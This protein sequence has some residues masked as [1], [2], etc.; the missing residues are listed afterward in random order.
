[1]LPGFDKALRSLEVFV[2]VCCHNSTPHRNSVQFRVELVV[3]SLLQSASGGLVHGLPLDSDNRQH[4][5][6]TPHACYYLP[7]SFAL[8][9]LAE[10]PS[11]T[12]RD[13]THFLHQVV[14]GLLRHAECQY[15]YPSASCMLSP[16]LDWR[17]SATLSFSS[18]SHFL[19]P[20]FLRLSMAPWVNGLS[21]N[22]SPLCH[23]RSAILMAAEMSFLSRAPRW[24]CRSELHC[25]IWAAACLPWSTS[26]LGSVCEERTWFQC[27][28]GCE[29]S[30]SVLRFWAA[31]MH[32]ELPGNNQVCGHLMQR[33]CDQG[34][35]CPSYSE[36]LQDR[37]AN[38]LGRRTCLCAWGPAAL[39]VNEPAVSV[40]LAFSG[41]PHSFQSAQAEHMGRPL[42]TVTPYTCCNR[43]QLVL[44]ETA[45]VA[46][47]CGFLTYTPLPWIWTCGSLEWD[48][49]SGARHNF[50]SW[51]HC[52]FRAFRFG[53]ALHPG[54][55]GC[56]D[57]APQT[58]KVMV[59]NPTAIYRKEAIFHEL[60]ADL[61]GIAETSAVE[62][63]QL[64]FS[65]GMRHYGYRTV[66]GA[67]VAMHGRDV[68]ASHSMR[69]LSGGVALA[70]KLPCRSSPTAF[71]PPMA[72]TTRL[73]ES[74]VRFGVL[75]IRCLCVYGVPQ[76]HQEAKEL[77]NALLAAAWD[78]VSQN[79]VP[80]LVLGDMNIDVHSLP[81]W[82]QY[83]QLGYVEAFRA[84]KAKFDEELPPTCKSSTRFDTAIM[85]PVLVELLSA[86]T[87]LSDAH[88]FDAHSPLQLEFAV[89]PCLPT[90]HRWRL[91]RPWTDFR[92]APEALAKQYNRHADAVQD[93]VSMV[94]TR[95]ELTGAFQT[96]AGAVEAAVDVTI[97]QDGSRGLPRAFRG[98]CQPT[99]RVSYTVQQLPRRARHGDFQ[100]QIEVISVKCRQRLRQCRR[101]RT[102]LQGLRKFQQSPVWNPAQLQQ[103]FNEWHAIL[104]APGYHGRFC[105]WVLSWDFMVHFPRDFPSVAYVADLVR[106]L[107]H[108]CEALAA[109]EAALRRAAYK[110]MVVEDEVVDF[111]R[112]GYKSLQGP[113]KPPFAAV[114]T[115]VQNVAHPEA[116]ASKGEWQFRMREAHLYRP[117]LQV[118]FQG[119]PGL[120]V[121]VNDS[122]VHAS[123]GQDLPCTSG[124]LTQHHHDCTPAEL[125]TGFQKFWQTYWLRDSP[126]EEADV[127]QWRQFLDLL[128][129]FPCPWESFELDLRDVELWVQ[130]CKKMKSRSATGACGFSVR[131]LKM[132]PRVALQQL[133]H[134]FHHATRVGL[135]DFLLLGRVN[136][137]AKTVDPQ[138]YNDGR[139]ICV[140]PVLY[141]AWTSVFCQQVLRR[142]APHLPPGL[143]GGV[144]GKSAKDITFK[145]QHDVEVSCAQDTP[146]SG[147]VLDI[148]KCFNAL[149]RPP[150]K[151]LMCRMGAPRPLV[152][153]WLE[154]LS[155]LGRASSFVGDIGEPCYSTTGVPEGDGASVAAAVAV[156]WLFCRLISSYG[157]DPLVFVDNWA[158]TTDC[159]AHHAAGLAQTCCL[160]DSLRLAVDW[161][162]SFA[163]SRDV[164]GRTWWRTHMS[165]LSPPGV[166]LSLLMEA[167]DLG[168]AMRYHSSRALGSLRHRMTQ[169]HERLSRL[170]SRPSTIQCKAR[171]IQ[172][173]IW[174]V[175]FYASEG[176][177]IGTKHIGSLR[178]AAARSLIGPHKQLSPFLAISALQPGLQDPEAYLLTSALRT[179][180]RVYHTNR[181]LAM[182]VLDIAQHATGEPGSVTG[183]GSALKALFRRN[184]W[185]I[186]GLVICTPGGLHF[187]LD[188]VASR[189]IARLVDKA[190]SYRVRLAVLHRNGL[191]S[192]GVPDP[193]TTSR[194]LR[195]LGAAAQRTLA[196]HILP[197]RGSQVQVGWRRYPVLSLLWSGGDSSPSLPG[198]SCLSQYP[199]QACSGSSYFGA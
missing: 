63:V 60:G 163:W 146:L 115:L 183:P 122:V 80:S 142:W 92:V 65:A 83:Q 134:L 114:T 181:P 38:P 103:L 175:A 127:G 72:H 74:M 184:E 144:P 79:K 71:T 22:L 44:R 132:L 76:S 69:G 97:K 35:D 186:Q 194:L 165:E 19:V 39:A 45:C 59:V 98:R 18:P 154:G 180:R 68:C 196:R 27:G 131:E 105:D 78:R 136:V 161:S 57:Q 111:C 191:Q 95:E 13:A 143:Y 101:A 41:G 145:L 51:D 82:P 58:I 188:K 50:C 55:I 197:N 102:L 70:T 159:H 148:Q 124:M 107:E 141:R 178:S 151:E 106:L 24:L 173:A 8:W 87:V 193:W 11:C 36:V 84:A 112:S 3:R 40:I 30:V 14:V 28:S 62:A 64:N 2:Q 33:S 93:V 86:A 139:P 96:W 135:P 152:H 113:S 176:F 67:P 116:V 190:W 10:Y 121:A 133:A 48:C 53:E 100:P 130:T 85:A 20:S 104:K 94:H 26:L 157:L 25:R 9:H 90:L 174:P 177:A 42:K 49:M 195:L 34:I 7:F 81:I 108:D 52:P 89:P 138:G 149:P 118:D 6:L 75:E 12:I 185:G 171:L 187:R 125:H 164:E 126:L 23:F 119:I 109:Q 189:D 167:K 1:M 170:A 117:G 17:L 172:S 199:R 198:L 156:G 168:A 31:S 166:Q 5:G 192:I 147:F 128:D 4:E 110:Q 16:V 182:S 43:R 73:V 162:K 46:R 61:Y 150:L 129:V 179:L 32:L 123:F 47:A 88:V 91:P 15:T 158:W 140:L 169:A 155:R 77:N 153:T 120:V 54:P 56:E 29:L 99:K 21:A 66:F 137:L 160:T 37:G